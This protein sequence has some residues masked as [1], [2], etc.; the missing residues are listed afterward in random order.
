TLGYRVAHGQDSCS[1]ITD[2][3][4]IEGGNYLGESMPSGS[5]NPDFEKRFND[6]LR[7]CRKGS[8]TVVFDTHFTPANLKPDWGHST[9][10]YALNLCRDAQVQRLILFHHAPED[11]DDD[12]RRKKDSIE[13][14]AQK[15]GIEVVIAREGDVWNL[16]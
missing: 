8:H 6:G 9:P 5:A 11:S 10:Q 16:S 1:I 2:Y 12:V 3:A 13:P 4:P 15:L 7:H 14:E